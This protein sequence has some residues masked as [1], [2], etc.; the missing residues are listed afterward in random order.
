MRLDDH[1]VLHQAELG[2]T[3]AVPA[4][5]CLPTGKEVLGRVGGDLALVVPPGGGPDFSPNSTR[6]EP[7]IPEM[8]MSALSQAMIERAKEGIVR[9]VRVSRSVT[10]NEGE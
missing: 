6:A 5:G 3:A 10:D 1:P 9:G 8:H 7:S 2:W 4:S